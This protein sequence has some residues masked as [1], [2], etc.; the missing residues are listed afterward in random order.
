M[1]NTRCKSKTI[2][3]CLINNIRIHM[4]TKQIIPLLMK[5]RI[6]MNKKIEG[7]KKKLNK[8]EKR[9]K[10]QSMTNYYINQIMKHLNLL[11]HKNNLLIKIRIIHR[12]TMKIS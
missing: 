2:E 3:T 12:L 6:Q 11:K 7:I 10:N 8:L 9:K 5:V 1:I 4:I